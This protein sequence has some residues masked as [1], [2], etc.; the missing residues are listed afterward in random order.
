M[1]YIEFLNSVDERINEMTIDELRMVIHNMARQ[2]K[3]DIRADFLKN[4][5]STAAAIEENNEDDQPI[6]IDLPELKLWCQKITDSE[7]YFEAGSLLDEEDFEF[8]NY[9]Y[10]DYE[11]L[12][13]TLVYHDVFEITPCLMQTL[14]TARK[15]MYHKEYDKARTVYDLVCDLKFQ[16]CRTEFDEWT[17]MT[18]QDLV[19]ADILSVSMNQ[20]LLSRLYLIYQTVKGEARSSEIYSLL[21]DSKGRYVDS[22]Y[23]EQNSIET[24]FS[25]GPE[26]IT[27]IPE[28]YTEWISFLMKT[29]DPYAGTLL[30]EACLAR[31]GM[32]L[33][34]YT[35]AQ[36]SITHPVLYK[37]A[38]ET[39]LSQNDFE[40]CQKTG[41]EAIRNI[42]QKLKIRGEIADLTG[43]AAQKLQHPEIVKLTDIEGFRSISDIP[44]FLNF[45]SYPDDP[46]LISDALLHIDALPAPSNPYWQMSIIKEAQNTLHREDKLLL[47]FFAGDFDPL[48]NESKKDQN[49]LGWS[50]SLKGIAVPLLILLLNK[51]S[52]ITR[53][54]EDLLQELSFRLGYNAVNSSQFIEQYQVWKKNIT[55]SD[56]TYAKFMPWIKEEVHYRTESIV[57]GGIRKS[58]YKAAELIVALGETMESRGIAN[59]KARIIDHYSKQ[60]NRKSAFKKELNK[61]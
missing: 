40:G 27:D 23:P 54:N 36:A 2:A 34:L 56:D 25:I 29:P 6:F 17:E 16:S 15:L 7:I 51:S 57:D 50:R 52:Q 43:Q 42:P 45:F 8:S 35:A 26:E 37:H 60:H 46:K 18:L 59:A 44:H 9:D 10:N 55:V 28:F 33:L 58:Y 20:L 5:A 38:M 30:I 61:R 47:S 24:M 11:E 22:L 19:Y 53:T 49:K 31:G 32:K 48:I 39:M 14:E 1:N 4:L 21:Y 41:L 12:R 3:E 13:D